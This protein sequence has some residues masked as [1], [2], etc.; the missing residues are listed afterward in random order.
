MEI[1]N[2]MDFQFLIRFLE[3]LQKFL[4]DNC[5]I[6]V[7]DYRKGYDHTIVYAFN[8]QLSGR[9]VGGSPRGGMITQLGNDIEPLKHSIISLDTSQKDR[10]FKSCTTLIEDEHHKIIGSVCLNMDVRN[11]YLAQSA[12]QSLIG[13][14]GTIGVSAAVGAQIDGVPG[15]TPSGTDSGNSAAGNGSAGNGSADG[16]SGANQPAMSD[17]DFILKKNVD[18]ILQHYIYQAESMIGKP[19]MLMNKE[20]K[21]RALDYLDQK[22]VFKITKTS[23]LLCDTM[24]I[25]KYTLYNYLEEARISRKSETN[26]G[27]S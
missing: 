9:D 26:E 24:Q 13:R 2:Y 27:E 11:L 20:E 25:Y 8:S 10:L 4:G 18:D 21:I 6:I 5:E 17:R 16:A 15:Y 3:G 14:P 12:L 23:L 19:M 1:S 7:H 22:G